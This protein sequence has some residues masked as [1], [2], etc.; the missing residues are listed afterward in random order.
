MTN[1]Q[2]IQKIKTEETIKKDLQDD[3]NE[4][5]R[6]KCDTNLPSRN[7]G[8]GAWKA[9]QKCVDIFNNTASPKKSDLS[10]IIISNPQFKISGRADDTL[11]PDFEDETGRAK[12]EAGIRHLYNF[13]D[14]LLDNPAMYGF[15]MDGLR[16]AC[17]AESNKHISDDLRKKIPPFIE[18]FYILRKKSS[19]LTEELAYLQEECSI[20]ENCFEKAFSAT[21]KILNENIESDH[22]SCCNLQSTWT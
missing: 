6:I 17:S 7:S 14:V 2:L 12:E 13:A 22:P 9:R 5:R 15:V 19:E 3:T 1:E 18:N 10:S 21:R 20:I 8:I 16:D 4:C 11:L